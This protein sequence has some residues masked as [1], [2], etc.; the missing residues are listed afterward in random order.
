M[1]VPSVSSESSSWAACGCPS[2]AVVKYWF[3]VVHIPGV[4]HREN[5][6]EL[7]PERDDLVDCRVFKEQS[8]IDAGGT[9][10]H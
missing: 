4:Y 8:I 1:K 10:H 9:V 7:D 6:R 2:Q 5:G 3:D